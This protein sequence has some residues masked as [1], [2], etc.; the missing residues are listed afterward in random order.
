[1]P[2]RPR[3]HSV[4]LRLV[5]WASL[6][7]LGSAC[8]SLDYDLSGVPIPVSAK[9]APVDAVHVE[10]FRLEVRHTLWAHGLLGRS[11]PDVATLVS[12]LA[13][14]HDRI[15]GFRVTQS[16]NIH[17]WLLTHL[18]LTLVRMKKVTIEGQFVS[19]T[20]PLPTLD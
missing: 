20:A 18:S 7:G 3:S 10:P 6:V 16:G 4:L 12:K 2:D 19:D 8:M 11:T 14:G 17:H 1:M 9:P 13:E 5:L 15:A